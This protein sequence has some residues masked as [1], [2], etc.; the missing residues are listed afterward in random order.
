LF[1][2]EVEKRRAAARQG[3]LLTMTLLPASTADIVAW[4]EVRVKNGWA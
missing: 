2:A 4:E 3:K 1:C